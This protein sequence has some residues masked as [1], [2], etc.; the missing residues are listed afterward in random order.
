MSCLDLV[1]VTGPQKA[2]DA[3]HDYFVSL[4]KL[5]LKKSNNISTIAIIPHSGQG[6]VLKM[7]AVSNLYDVVWT[8]VSK[9]R[10]ML[11][12]RVPIPLFKGGLG[13]RGSV[14][15]K[16]AKHIFNSISDTAELSQYIACQGRHWPDAN[17]LKQAGLTVQLVSHFDAM[18]QMLVLKRCDYMPLS[19]FEGRAELAA[20]EDR[21]PMLMFNEKWLISYPITMNF[22]VKKS[23]VE[24]ANAIEKGLLELIDTGEFEQHMRQ[25][26]LTKNGFPLERLRDAVMIEIN[27]NDISQQTLDELA[28]YGFKWPQSKPKPLQS[29]LH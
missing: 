14:M 25:H 26:S 21:F 19:I 17:I 3:S 29:H 18:L 13:L 12:H 27:N 16:D 24:L 7:L 20:V 4:L 6:R 15:R 10:D 2:A 23:N 8:G 5:S 11:L 28:N 22:Y 9:E 1:K